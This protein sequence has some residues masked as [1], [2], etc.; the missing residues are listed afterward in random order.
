MNFATQFTVSNAG[1]TAPINSTQKKIHDEKVCSFFFVGWDIF[2]D[3]FHFFDANIEENS[4][5]A[6]FITIV[7]FCITIGIRL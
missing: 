1:A 7:I 2:H 3:L 4:S 6:G 5:S